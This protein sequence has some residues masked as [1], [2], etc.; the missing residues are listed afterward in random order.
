MFA[1]RYYSRKIL[2]R[3]VYSD[4]RVNV[5]KLKVNNPLIQINYFEILQVSLMI[6][7]FI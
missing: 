7:Y 6:N 3:L 1:E 2:F 4:Y 5:I